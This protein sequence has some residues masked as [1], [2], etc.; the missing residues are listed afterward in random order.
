[1]NKDVSVTS[2]RNETTAFT[3]EPEPDE[4]GYYRATDEA[5]FS[6][7]IEELMARRDGGYTMND[8]RTVSNYPI[9]ES[10]R[11]TGEGRMRIRGTDKVESY[12][13]SKKKKK[14]KIARKSRQRNQK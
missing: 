13:K 12:H 6:D 14:S 3:K 4:Y 1:M 11:I 8:T 9:P 5:S 2:Y 10:N 7:M